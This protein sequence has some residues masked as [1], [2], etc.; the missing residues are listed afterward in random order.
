MS[1]SKLE[2]QSTCQN[3]GKA[4]RFYDHFNWNL[5]GV[6]WRENLN[7]FTDLYLSSYDRSKEQ[8]SIKAI[9]FQQPT[10]KW[11]CQA[12]RSSKPVLLKKS[13]CS[14]H[15]FIQYKI[16][17]TIFVTKGL[18]AAF[19]QRKP[20]FFVRLRERLLKLHVTYLKR[21]HILC[22]FNFYIFFPWLPDLAIKK[23]L[24]R[25]PKLEIYY[26]CSS[27]VW[28]GIFERVTIYVKSPNSLRSMTLSSRLWRSR[29]L[30]S[31]IWTF[32]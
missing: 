27:E 13:C 11:I 29:W 3:Q 7:T 10:V 15:F 22:S 18:L 30:H 4:C 12:P 28:D 16:P 26:K 25:C 17:R 6:F 21:G 9:F 32:F 20:L 23:Y 14:V 8:A 2:F 31:K 5:R 19:F 1:I 24:D